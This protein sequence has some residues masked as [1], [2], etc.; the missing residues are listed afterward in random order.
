MLYIQVQPDQT[1]AVSVSVEPVYATLA[2]RL[3]QEITTGIIP[4]GAYLPSESTLVA[5]QGVARGTVRRAID[6]LIAEGLVVS[7]NGRGHQVRQ[8][9]ALVWRASEPE[10]NNGRSSGPSDAWSRGVREQNHEPSEQI[11]AEIAY[12]DKRVAQWLQIEP[13][14]PVS[15]RRRLRFV[16]GSPYS[17]ADSFYPRSIVAGTEV[18]LPGDVQPGIYAVF[19]RIGRPWVRTV[20]RWIPRAPTRDEAIRL[21]IPRGVSVAEVVRR[22]FDAAG[23][24]VRLSLFVLPGDRHE[25]EY[26]HEEART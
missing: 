5:Q 9:T 6:E 19:D 10:R 22:S 23:I 25:I 1:G 21:Q 20:D 17:T 4:P 14:E 13:G 8:S 12:A 7:H 2:A 15:V 26:E 24:P 16:D 11:T 18:E 3:R